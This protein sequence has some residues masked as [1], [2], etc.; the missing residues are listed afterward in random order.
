MR[1]K[2]FIRLGA[3]DDAPAS[4]VRYSASGQPLGA[5]AHGALADAAAS[6]A[7][8]R[9][10]VFAPG[11]DVLLTRVAIPSQNRARIAQA[12]PFVLEEQL[13]CDVED[14]HFAVG[15]R[16]ADK[17]INAAVV[18]RTRMERW[19]GALREAGI[20]PDVLTPETLGVPL[21][22]D[23]WTV[24]I[25]PERGALVRNGAQSG[26]A[27][28]LISLELMLTSLLGAAESAKPARIQILHYGSDAPR[29]S[30]ELGVEVIGKAVTE[31]PLLLLA[32]GFDEQDAV[33]LMQGD[34]SRRE[35]LGKLWRPWR[36]AAAL[37]GAWLILQGGM[38]AHEIYRLSRENQAL[39]QQIQRVYLQTF[40]E[41]R[42]VVNP[43]VQM[44]RQLDAL[45]GAGQGDQGFL[46]LLARSGAPFKDTPNLDLRT[47]SYKDGQL[48]V[49]LE[50]KDLQ[51]LDQLKQRL[52]AQLNVDIQ[53]ATSQE[54][55][56]QSR[57]QIQAKKS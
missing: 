39:Q 24:L 8:C 34:Y 17:Q 51:A 12:L 3:S 19:L 23:A 43:R 6:A 5:V 38:T 57:L 15:R 50:I 28:D 26:L 30:G 42:K 47:V 41:S 27:A 13:A 44:Q 37:L 48:N 1:D 55:K 36:A 2:L 33:N 40:P 56:V 46:E 22:P 7:G 21:T 53:S 45:R 16:N 20:Q 25:L 18:A 14:L 29:L 49:D 31:E 54:D 4:W 32:R 52:A 35:Q 9:V 10:I 11:G